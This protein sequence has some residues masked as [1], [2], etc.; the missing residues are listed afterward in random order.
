VVYEFNGID[1]N[2]VSSIKIEGLKTDDSIK[3]LHFTHLKAQRETLTGL[4]SE[5][6]AWF[7]LNQAKETIFSS[8]IVA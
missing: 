7:I 6:G 2:K 5:Q 1:V 4:L 8:K 3:K